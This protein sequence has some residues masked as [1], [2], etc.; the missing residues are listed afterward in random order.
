MIPYS[1]PFGYVYHTI[2]ALPLDADWSARA[3]S[4]YEVH[5][6]R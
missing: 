3:I 5:F 2:P 1:N 4:N 6:I